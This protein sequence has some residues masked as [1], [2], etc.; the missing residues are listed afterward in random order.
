MAHGS[1]RRFGCDRDAGFAAPVQQGLPA[2]LAVV[3]GCHQEG[4]LGQRAVMPC[5]LRGAEAGDD[6]AGGLVAADRL[7]G[8]VVR[9]G[10]QD[11]A[12]GEINAELHAYTSFSSR[13]LMGM[14]APIRTLPFFFRRGRAHLAALVR[15][16]T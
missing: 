1:G 6:G 4:T 7:A 9:A 14:E 12:A 11:F 8:G 3:D 5:A 13:G 15:R 2:G 16:Q 10:D